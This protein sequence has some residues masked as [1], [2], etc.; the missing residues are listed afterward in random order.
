MCTIEWVYRSNSVF[1]FIYNCFK[2]DEIIL[3]Y[4]ICLL[5]VE[6]TRHT[7]RE[8]YKILLKL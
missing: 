8:S 5:I 6:L 4:H 1:L 7:S 2:F 3:I